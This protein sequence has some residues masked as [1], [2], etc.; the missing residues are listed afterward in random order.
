MRHNRVGGLPKLAVIVLR[1]HRRRLSLGSLRLAAAG[2]A[3]AGGGLFLATGAAGAAPSPFGPLLELSGSPGGGAYLYGVSCSDASDCT[4]VGD[5]NN[6]QPIY[7]T[8]TAGTW[9]ARSRSLSRPP[10]PPTP[11]G[12]SSA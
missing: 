8:E 5:D 7:A 11:S 3:V 12:T 1:R 9:A 6:G 10:L 2:L 4:A